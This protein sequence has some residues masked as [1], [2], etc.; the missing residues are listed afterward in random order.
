MLN[1]T[2]IALTAATVLASA[3]AA[4][5][6][7]APE[8]RIGDRYPLLEQ[9]YQPNTSSRVTSAR[10]SAPRSAAPVWAFNLNQF[11]NSQ[12]YVNDAP[13]NKIGD[14]YPF[15]EPKIQSQRIRGNKTAMRHHK[16]NKA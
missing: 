3:S 16:K 5:A 12:Q 10:M 13:E 15:L 4:F 2:I 1:K 9:G 7:D 14:R 8:N 6:Y 11:S